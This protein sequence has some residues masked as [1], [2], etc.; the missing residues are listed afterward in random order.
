ME[1]QNFR[2]LVVDDNEA[3]LDM[4]SRRLQR[5]GFQV[6]TAEGG[7]E[8]LDI[9]D[10]QTVDLVLLDIMMPGI[11]GLEVLRR[12][13]QRCSPLELPII[14]ATAKAG[15]D[16]IVQT[17]AL[18]ANDHV[19][20]P[21]DF[22]VVVA[23]IQALLRTKSQAFAAGLGSGGTATPGSTRIE[24]GGVLAGR[25]RLDR[26]IGSG[27]FG[28]VYRAHHMDLAYD[29]AIKVLH[30]SVTGSE[31]TRRRFHLEGVAACR[32]QHP[33]AV[34]VTDFGVTEDGI[35]YLVME[36]LEGFSLIQELRQWK[37]L[38]PR[39]YLEV[40]GPVC[41]V[42]AQAHRSG[43]VHRDIKPENIFLHQSNQGEVVKLLDFGIAKLVG[44]NAVSQNLTAEGWV[45]GTPAYMAPERLSNEG[46]DG[47]ADVYSLGVMLFE[48]LT[49]SRPFTAVNNDPMAMIMRHVR[50][51]PPS[52]QSVYANAPTS[53]EPLIRRCLAKQP[54]DR[55][56]VE[57]LLQELEEVVSH[58]EAD[59][60]T[61]TAKSAATWPEDSDPAADSNRPTTTAL[62]EVLVVGLDDFESIDGEAPTIQVASD[63][64]DLTGAPLAGSSSAQ[65]TTK[66][67]LAATVQPAP[68]AVPPDPP[69]ASRG[70][71]SDETGAGDR[72]EKSGEATGDDDGWVRR[73][74][75]RFRG[76]T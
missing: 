32:V 60:Q 49:G 42:L 20:K 46:Y 28:V 36:L 11:D 72:D 40:L 15:S 31:E 66:I 43:L 53:L 5:R 71:T 54:A 4:L 14:M 33:N 45:L 26:L 21:L 56:T 58:L 8:A 24:V 12:T 51:P 59:P 67:R 69:S 74:L 7:A 13:R 65:A 6:L 25:Y 57:M 18:G 10:Q 37:R 35:A 19:V 16:D 2:L 62:P 61:R 38:T 50:E 30:P 29:V 55:P 27:T 22:K 52:L 3:N 64:V 23:K 39:R 70:E 34:R 44:E 63:A 9:L 47:R 48:M 75:R 73:W 41:E 1:N 17:A 68:T 76:S